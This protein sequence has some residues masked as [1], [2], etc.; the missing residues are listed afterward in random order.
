M[1]GAQLSYANYILIQPLSETY[2]SSWPLSAC[3][4]KTWISDLPE[5]AQNK[6]T[7]FSPSALRKS[8]PPFRNHHGPPPPSYPLYRHLPGATPFWPLFCVPFKPPLSLSNSHYN[9]CGSSLRIPRNSSNQT[10][11]PHNR[12][13]LPSVHLQCSRWPW[14]TPHKERHYCDRIR[15]SYL[16]S[17]KESW[18]DCKWAS[19]LSATKKKKPN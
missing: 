4:N 7:F 15:Q 3:R 18:N 8:P 14:G 13:S 11:S 10:P 12:T 16:A 17:E 5:A 6:F 1:A 19:L 2:I 9:L